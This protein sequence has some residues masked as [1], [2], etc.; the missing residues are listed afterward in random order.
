M[1]ILVL[2]SSITQLDIISDWTTLRWTRG[3]NAQGG[4]ELSIHPEDTR[5]S[6][7]MTGN[8]LFLDQQHIGMI[9]S[10]DLSRK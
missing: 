4:F 6:H 3:W 7:L 2:D 10:V 1:H 9:E 8:I 5:T